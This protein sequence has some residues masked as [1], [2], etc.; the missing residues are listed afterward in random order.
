MSLRKINDISQLIPDSTVLSSRKQAWR[1]LEVIHNFYSYSELSVPAYSS[2]I[3]AVHFGHPVTLVEKIDGRTHESCLRKG[4]VTIVPAGLPSKWCRLEGEEIDVINM[5]L[6]PDFLRGVAAGI[7]DADPDRIEIISHLGKQDAQITHIGYALRAAIEENKAGS[8]LYAESLATA[9]AVHLLHNYCATTQPIRE[10]TGGLPPHKFRRVREYINEHIQ[11]D[12]SLSDLAEVS[13]MSP[14]HFA[15]QFKQ[16]TGLSPH[17]Y[18]T[19]RR[20]EQAKVLLTKTDLSITEIALRVGC[21]SQSHLSKLFRQ[22]T[23]ISPKA[24]RQAQS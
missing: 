5:H 12:L 13:A 3:I 16:T 4:D 1:G 2:H 22:V 8:Q 7:S 18:V 14:Y 9:L 6:K 24:Y 20:I 10:Y 23:G 11:D 17:Q 19:L 21:A 15:R